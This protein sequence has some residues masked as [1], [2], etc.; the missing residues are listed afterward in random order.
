MWLTDVMNSPLSTLSRPN[1]GIFAVAGLAWPVA[2]ASAIT[3]DFVA[4]GD[5]GNPSGTYYGS[6]G[7]DYA[8]GTYEVTLNQYAAFLNAVARTDSYGLYNVSMGTNLN[9]AGIARSGSS[10]SF[11]YAVMGDGQRPVTYVGWF[12]TLRF[13]NWLQNGQPNTGTQTV[14]TTEQGAYA[15]N[16]ATSGTNFIRSQTAQYWIPSEDEWN[17]AAYYQPVAKGGP[18]G[19]YWYYPT[20]SNTIPNSR[21]GSSTDPNS[22]NFIRDDG[23]ANG[24]ND[25]Y[26]VNGGSGM[27]SNLNYLTPVGAF[28]LAKSYYGTYDQGGNVS[29]WTASLY[30]SSSQHILGGSFQSDS[31]FLQENTAF[32]N[33]TDAESYAT[34]FRVA[35]VPEP[36]STILL[37]GSVLAWIARRKKRS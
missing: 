29:E 33:V 23:L 35:M 22:A 24:F 7:Y 18:S 36:S 19:G 34:G 4:V 6:V 9:I 14:A 13:A 37:G 30:P 31:G 11:S 25:G 17:K 12:D 15:L 27:Q 10:G 28:S 20:A 32:A 26:A 5:P 8:I 3:L 16:G 21:N 1:L 2:S